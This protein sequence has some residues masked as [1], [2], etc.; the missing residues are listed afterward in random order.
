MKV[1]IIIMA[2]AFAGC[3]AIGPSDPEPVRAFYGIVYDQT[4][5]VEGAMVRIYCSA[6]WEAGHKS[7]WQTTSDAKGE[8][9][10]K[11]LP[12]IDHAGHML[13]CKADRDGKS[14][15]FYYRAQNKGGVK[16]PPFRLY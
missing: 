2:L 6:C 16:I 8:W 3:S 4:E 7:R 10:I 14:D 5:G 9:V 15:S 13:E 11:D 12:P 1:V